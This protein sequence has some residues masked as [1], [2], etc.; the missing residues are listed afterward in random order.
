MTWTTRNIS[1]TNTTLDQGA[2][3]LVPRFFQQLQWAPPVGL[4][5]RLRP[6]S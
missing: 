6:I 2:F 3:A 1:R 5:L 4:S